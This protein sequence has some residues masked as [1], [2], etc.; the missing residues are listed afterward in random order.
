MRITVTVGRGNVTKLQIGYSD[1]KMFNFAD[2]GIT[3]VQVIVNDTVESST[4][5]NVSFT[6]DVLYVKFG[7]MSIV[8][9]KCYDVRIVVYYGDD[10]EGDEILGR[11]R[12]NNLLLMV[13]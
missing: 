2:E 11:L 6:D 8:S 3:E 13:N 7:K 10:L 12:K 5:D 9:G 1:G 4:G